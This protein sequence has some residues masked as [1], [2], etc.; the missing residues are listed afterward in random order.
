MRPLSLI[1]FLQLCLG[2]SLHCVAQSGVAQ[3]TPEQ[4]AERH[5]RY[6]EQLR[7]DWA[8]TQKYAAENEKL[9]KTAGAGGAVYIG[10]SITEFW[11]KYDSAF[12]KNNEFIDRGISGQT[13]SQMLVRF[14]RDVVDQHPRVVVIN[15]GTNDIAEN[16][17]PISLEGILGNIMSMSEIARANNVKVVLTAVLPAAE[18]PWRKGKEPAEKVVKLNDMIRRY[19]VA[20]KLEYVDYWTPLA[21]AAKEMDKKYSDDGIHPNLA[22]YKV[23]ESEVKGVVSGLLKK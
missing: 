6:D 15:A 7:N 13:S 8:Q 3:L 1:L 22:G 5:R 14:R 12:W 20:N 11:W 2:T 10:D 18:F 23:M 21:D 4:I 19:A 17:G 9:K 16:T